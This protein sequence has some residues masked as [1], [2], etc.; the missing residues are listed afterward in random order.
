MKWEGRDGVAAMD[1]RKTPGF[2]GVA[3]LRVA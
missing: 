1:G 2:L 3:G